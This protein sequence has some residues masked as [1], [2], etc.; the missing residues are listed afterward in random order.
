MKPIQIMIYSITMLY[1]LM[2]EQIHM[3]INN[4]VYFLLFP[5]NQNKI[6]LFQKDILSLYREVEKSIK[7][8]KVIIIFQTYT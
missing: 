2:S 1:D 3:A 7:D 6:S 8:T 4:L 5:D